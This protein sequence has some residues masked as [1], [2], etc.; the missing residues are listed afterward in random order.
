MLKDT[1]FSILVD[2]TPCR[3]GVGFLA[4]IA[5]T[6]TDQYVTEC[7]VIAAGS[8]RMAVPLVPLDAAAGRGAG[9]VGSGIHVLDG[10]QVGRL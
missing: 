1:F 4:V 7:R 10:T 2:E 8:A 6:A 5:S 3:D 9:A